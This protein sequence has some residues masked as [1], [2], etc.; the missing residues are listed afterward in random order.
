MSTTMHV[1]I[2]GYVTH[3]QLTTNTDN[4]GKLRKSLLFRLPEARDTFN[5]LPDIEESIIEEEVTEKKDVRS[6]MMDRLKNII[7]EGL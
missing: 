6:N 3:K 2:T 7:A 4:N 5:E 1:L